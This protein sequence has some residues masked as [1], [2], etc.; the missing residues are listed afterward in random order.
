MSKN[1]V[2]VESPAKAK[3]IEKFLGKAYTVKSSYGHV[4]DLA[5]KNFGIDV[6]NNFKPEYIVMPDKK[7]IVA[8][9]KKEVKNADTVLLAS[10]EDREGEAIAWHLYEVLN[11]KK[12]ETKRIV[13]NE[14]TENA[15]QNAVDNPGNINIDLVNAQQ[16]RRVLDRLVGFKLSA[17][18]WKKVQGKLSAGR[19]QSVAVKLLV[20]RER[21]IINFK[22]QS[23]FKVVAE[24]IGDENGIKRKF[25]ADLSEKLKTEKE[26]ISFLE[27]LNN[28]TFKVSNI[29]KKPGKRSPS[30]PF[31]TS[32]LQQEAGRKLGFPV[33]KTMRVAQKLYEAGQITYMR[34]DS[35]NLSSLAINTAKKVI[36]D[37]FGEKLQ[38]YDVGLFFY[39]G[40]GVQVK[41]SNYLVPVDA[42]IS[43]ESDVE[44]D[45]VNA[46]RV[47]ARMEDAGSNV[48]IVILDA[49]RNNPFERS[50]TRS[51]QGK[52]LAFMNAPS[53]S[54]IAYA[55]SPG[56]TASDGSGNNGLYT[57]ALLKH[58]AT[59]DITILEMF[60][61]VRTTVMKESG[62]RQVPWE[63]TSLRGNF[64]FVK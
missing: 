51:T 42:N 9:L 57:S 12:K 3:T 55:T 39:A 60:Q 41:G 17:V 23:S 31:T 13:F 1:L 6:E 56:T 63:S 14:I 27:G 46:E 43:S 4:R 2:I 25:K 50:W 20:E 61:R 36:L 62:D 18:L 52:G 35:V 59:P 40:H 34:T 54:L 21:E 22:P 53:G 7:K 8:E 64:Y 19:V 48:N 26:V 11:L 29:E 5:K 38:S 15:I 58:L 16:A 30:A 44:Y 45:C 32:S 28:P 24:F 10:D 47:L 49:C 33:G 37:E